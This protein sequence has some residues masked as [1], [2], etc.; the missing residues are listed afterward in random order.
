MKTVEMLQGCLRGLFEK[1]GAGVIYQAGDLL[2]AVRMKE[3]MKR[4]SKMSHRRHGTF[5]K[6]S[7]PV[8]GKPDLEDVLFGERYVCPRSKFV[9]GLN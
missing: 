2:P 6:S 7:L 3:M 8:G 9:V 1:D 5:R 4:L